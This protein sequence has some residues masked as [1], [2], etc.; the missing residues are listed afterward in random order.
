[1]LQLAGL[2]LGVFGF[3]SMGKSGL[4]VWSF[5]SLGRGC[6]DVMHRVRRLVAKAAFKNH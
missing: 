6:R 4:L 2:F 5:G 3:G 1:M